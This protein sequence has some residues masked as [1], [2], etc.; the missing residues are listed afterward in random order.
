MSER[1]VESEM[2]SKRL[3]VSDEAVPFVSRGGRIFL[4]QVIGVDPDIHSGEIVQ[5]VDRRDHLLT[6]ATAIL[7]PEEIDQIRKCPD[8]PSWSGKNSPANN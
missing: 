5:I 1:N 6:I 3:V 7:T 4:K 2:P 8:L